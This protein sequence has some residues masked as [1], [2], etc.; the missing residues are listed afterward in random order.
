MECKTGIVHLGR[1]TGHLSAGRGEWQ[2]IVFTLSI[3]DHSRPL[4]ILTDYFHATRLQLYSTTQGQ[5][6]VAKCKHR[7]L[8]LQALDL[9]SHRTAPTYVYWV[10]PHQGFTPNKVAD[11]YAKLALRLPFSPPKPSSARPGN[12][13]YHGLPLILPAAL[14]LLD[15]TNLHHPPNLDGLHTDRINMY[16]SSLPLLHFPNPKLVTHMHGRVNW[17]PLIFSWWHDYK[18]NHFCRLCSTTTHPTDVFSCLSKCEKLRDLTATALAGGYEELSPSIL[19][20]HCTASPDDHRDFT[21]CLVS[22]SLIDH[23]LSNRQLARFEVLRKAYKS[24]YLRILASLAKVAHELPLSPTPGGAL[25]NTPV[26][27]HPNL[28]QDSARQAAIS[29]PKPHHQPAA[30]KKHSTLHISYTSS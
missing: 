4:L 9:V 21:R 27:L 13:F 24:K 11:H 17:S 26:P 25:L 30:Y 1:T 19:L 12:W 29:S 7:D 15:I 8:I 2:S 14:P 5:K 20:W 28:T 3:A 23:L 10:K 22:N 18:D 6:K 16:F